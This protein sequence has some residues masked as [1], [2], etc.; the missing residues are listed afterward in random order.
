ML[1][2]I[3]EAVQLNH[4]LQELEINFLAEARF[5]ERVRAT[6]DQFQSSAVDSKSVL[7]YLHR[8]DLADGQESARAR[9]VWSK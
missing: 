6:A 1:E 3:P 9:T 2:S 5:G 8:L 4:R 7:S